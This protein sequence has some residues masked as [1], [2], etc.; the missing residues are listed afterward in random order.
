MRQL[1]WWFGWIG[2]N[3]ICMLIVFCS[4]MCQDHPPGLVCGKTNSFQFLQILS[5]L[6]QHWQCVWYDAS[7]CKIKREVKIM[8]SLS[9]V[10]N[11][12]KTNAFI[13]HCSKYISLIKL[14]YSKRVQMIQLKKILVV[15]EIYFCCIF[16][17]FLFINAV[18]W[19]LRKNPRNFTAHYHSWFRDWF[20]VAQQRPI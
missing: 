19:L 3:G 16:S 18:W 10:F 13:I 14:F 11:N 12:S 17:N 9:C 15:L 7:W 20:L 5:M 6:L 8:P 1:F 2:L 4:I